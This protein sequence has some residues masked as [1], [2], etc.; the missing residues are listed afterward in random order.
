[1]CDVVAHA[2]D[3]L[4]SYSDGELNHVA[5]DGAWRRRIREGGQDLATTRIVGVGDDEVVLWGW[6]EIEALDL[7]TGAL[8]W[9]L[10]A[11]HSLDMDAGTCV[12]FGGH[13]LLPNGWPLD[14]AARGWGAVD[15]GDVAIL[16]RASARAVDREG[17]L[18]G[19]WDG[20]LF[21]WRP[22]RGCARVG[23][24]DGPVCG[25]LSDER[26][27]ALVLD[28]GRVVTEDHEHSFELELR[29]GDPRARY[30][31]S[32]PAWPM[33]RRVG[34]ALL[35]VANDRDVC[36]AAT[37]L[38]G[39]ALFRGAEALYRGEQRGMSIL[40]EGDAPVALVPGAALVA[41]EMRRVELPGVLPSA[42]CVH[43]GVLAI[44]TQGGDLLHL[45]L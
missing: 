13:V 1:M 19:T 27:L 14:L 9:S 17:V 18:L 35:V 34:D 7:Q 25:L 2:D 28:G 30:Y 32:W 4:V 40:P 31:P 23:A 3:L 41:P 26:G 42:A 22:G 15:D 8:R 29:R 21:R 36:F 16:E 20:E 39:V 6:E 37:C 12:A 5:L 43:R 24:V 38:S 44:G 45:A 11:G 10:E 33:L